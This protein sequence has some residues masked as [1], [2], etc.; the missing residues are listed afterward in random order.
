MGKFINI[1]SQVFNRL[2]VIEIAKE[3]TTPGHIWWRCRCQCGKEV[4]LASS[5]I[6]SGFTKSCG[7]LRKEKGRDMLFRHGMKNSREYS[8]WVHMLGRCFNP[9][10]GKFPLYGGRGIKVC[11]RWQKFENFYSDIG[12]KPSSKHSINR[13]NNNGPYS[14]DNCVWSTSIEQSRNK[15]NNIRVVYRGAS[16]TIMEWAEILDI[17]YMTL[18][19]RI[20]RLKW[21]AEN[22][23]ETSSKSHFCPDPR[24]MCLGR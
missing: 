16:K 12:P 13:V 4:V 10:N 18:H 8:A 14:P 24:R 22:A 7:C 23:I 21:S 17:P 9:R 11:E 15:N 2:T 20:V 1:T 5:Q 3:K 6:R 19:S